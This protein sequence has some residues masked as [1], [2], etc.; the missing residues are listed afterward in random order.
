MST[1]FSLMHASKHHVNLWH[2]STD[3]ISWGKKKRK[4]NLSTYLQ[5]HKHTIWQT[6]PHAV[7]HIISYKHLNVLYTF[8]SGNTKNAKLFAWN[9]LSYV[10]LYSQWQIWLFLTKYTADLQNTGHPRTVKQYFQIFTLQVKITGINSTNS[11]MFR[12]K[13]SQ[14]AFLMCHCQII[15]LLIKEHISLVYIQKIY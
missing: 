1:F 15:N 3:I 4:Q 11:N 6:S 2:G 7:H 9:F 13:F 8:I 12:R 10:H 5:H 14:S